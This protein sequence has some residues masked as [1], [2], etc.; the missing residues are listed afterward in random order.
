MYLFFS[1]KK[2]IFSTVWNI[3]Y[4]KQFA[5]IY[6]G[7]YMQRSSFWTAFSSSSLHF[8]LLAPEFYV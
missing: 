1:V 2:I 7:S 6:L 5:C 4:N 8:N 3:G